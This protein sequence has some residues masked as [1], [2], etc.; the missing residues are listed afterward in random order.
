[1]ATKTE[2]I[3]A[4][5]EPDLKARTE[6]IFSELGMTTSDA[7]VLFLKQV[8]L[9]RGIPFELSVPQERLETKSAVS[10][11]GVKT[12]DQI[13]ARLKS[14]YGAKSVKGDAIHEIIKERDEHL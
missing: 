1:M 9:K 11:K 12:A 2:Y 5:I 3:R 4:R 6:H 13:R 7:I 8:S 14:I 10:S